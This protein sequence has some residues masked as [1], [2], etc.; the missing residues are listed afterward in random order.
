M[1]KLLLFGFDDLPSVAAVAAAAVPMGIE[2]VP[3]GRREYDRPL[4]V[5]AGLVPG[6]EGLPFAGGPLGGRMIV[7]CGLEKQLDELLPALAKAGAG[8]D[9]LKAVLTV[10]NRRWSARKLF[11][12]LDR[13]RRAFMKGGRP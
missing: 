6:G 4:E 10:H 2:I 11:G 12:E 13:E 7:L 3:V 1:K 8:P 9:C 5:L